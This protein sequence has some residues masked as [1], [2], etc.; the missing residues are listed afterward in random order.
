MTKKLGVRD[1][2]VTIRILFFQKSACRAPTSEGHDG[3]RLARGCG[4]LVDRNAGAAAV[5]GAGVRAYHEPRRT[6]LARGMSMSKE[7]SSYQH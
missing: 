6:R 1:G 3:E 2:I 5:Q 4:R 7:N